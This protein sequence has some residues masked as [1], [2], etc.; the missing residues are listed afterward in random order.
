M[1]RKSNIARDK[2]RVKLVAKYAKKR[3]ELKEKG[4]YVALQE[5]PLNSSPSR[6]KNRCFVSGRPRGFMRDFGI[7]R[8]EFRKLA[9]EGK[10]PGVKKASW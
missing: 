3:A 1:A 10:I 9:N 4:D 5:L 2:K 6:L 8:I 7:N